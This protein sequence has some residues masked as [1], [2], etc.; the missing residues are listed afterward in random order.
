MHRAMKETKK[1]WSRPRKTEEIHPRGT[2]D[3]VV[4]SCTISN[5]KTDTRTALK[6]AQVSWSCGV[7]SRGVKRGRHRDQQQTDDKGASHS[8]KRDSGL[9]AAYMYKGRYG[10]TID[11]ELP[12]LH[13]ISN[14]KT[15]TSTALKGKCRP[16]CSVYPRAAKEVRRRPP[17]DAQE[18]HTTK[19]TQGRPWLT[20][21]EMLKPGNRQRRTSS[22]CMMPQWTQMKGLLNASRGEL[23]GLYISVQIY[24]RC[25]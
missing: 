18:H 17:V 14:D 9:V 13:D 24:D 10:G 7:C 12:P 25:E 8:S 4:F 6:S 19:E 1:G 15:D 11:D 22:C 20:K 16:A 3:D 5:E 23:N 21:E 2:I